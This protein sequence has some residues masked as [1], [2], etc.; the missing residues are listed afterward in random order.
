[1]SESPRHLRL[2]VLLP[3]AALS[4]AAAGACY[5]AAG[6]GLGLVIGGLF[7]VTFL[8]PA[9]AL[10]SDACTCPLPWYSGGG[11]GWRFFCSKRGSSWVSVF[12]VIAPITIAWLIAMLNSSERAST[13]LALILMLI[14]YALAVAGLARLFFAIGVYP[15]YASALTIFMGVLSLTWPIW[16]SPEAAAMGKKTI[17]RLAQIN[18]PLVAGGV[19]A[20]EPAWTERSIAYGLTTLNQD[21]PISL[22]PSTA[23]ATL[24]HAVLAFIFF[25]AEH[26]FRRARRL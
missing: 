18:P 12:A 13:W 15:I 10:Q 6:P 7:V 8:M 2:K 3:L 17:N 26:A 25:A 23:Q 24:A 20:T 9:A 5:W 19:L 22:P 21:V 14:A 1:V 16:L 4:S 11:L